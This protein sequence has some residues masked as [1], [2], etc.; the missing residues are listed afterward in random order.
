MLSIP[1]KLS[2]VMTPM[3]PS[4]SS[5]LTVAGEGNLVFNAFCTFRNSG[6]FTE[7]IAPF[8]CRRISGLRREIGESALSFSIQVLRLPNSLRRGLEVVLRRKTHVLHW[9]SIKCLY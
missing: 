8:P 9:S 4:W 1:E 3:M 2:D 6:V 5:N 7:A